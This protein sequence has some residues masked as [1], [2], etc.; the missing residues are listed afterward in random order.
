MIVGNNLLLNIFSLCPI[1]SFMKYCQFIKSISILNPCA[2][3]T[4]FFL[5]WSS[6]QI[7]CSG[8]TRQRIRFRRIVFSQE[9]KALTNK[10]HCLDV[11]RAAQ[12]RGTAGHVH[13][14]PRQS[15]ADRLRE[16]A[17]SPLEANLK[18]YQTAQS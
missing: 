16:G 12:W 3:Q 14:T 4:S 6:H 2:Y 13:S 15:T 1:K 9:S 18:E 10:Y 11:Q 17:K 5:P 7:I 8:C